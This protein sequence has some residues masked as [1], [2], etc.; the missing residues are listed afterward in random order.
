[1][2]HETKGVV[3]AT[4]TIEERLAG[5]HRQIEELQTKG[6]AGRDEA[7]TRIE[8]QLDALREQETSARAAAKEGIDA[9]REKSEQFEARLH[10][11]QSA[12][13]TELAD[14]R[15]KFAD[16]LEHELQEWDRY[17]ERLQAQAA[18][19]AAS[20]RQQ[21]EAAISDLRRRRN[22]VAERLT[23]IRGAS[24]A[25]WGEQKQRIVAARDELEG[26]A[27]ELSAKFK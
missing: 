3:M 6:R 13:A 26:K 16:A 25:G 7:R 4:T 27:D 10:V 8:R 20:A 23:A 18:L 21:S 14:G 5:M 17:F 11:A 24:A 9:F 1:M 2:D 19:R 12:I 22:A 15:Q